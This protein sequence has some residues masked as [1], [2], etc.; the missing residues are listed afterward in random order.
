MLTLTR[1]WNSAR[2][3]QSP[4]DQGR[5]MKRAQF[6]EEQITLQSVLTHVA[7]DKAS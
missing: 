5:A 6:A 3:N 1:P 4:P 7:T 2:I